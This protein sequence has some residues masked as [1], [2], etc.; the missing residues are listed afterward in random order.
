M[1]VLRCISLLSDDG[2]A[3]PIIFDTYIVSPGQ[4]INQRN[5]DVPE[6]RHQKSPQKAIS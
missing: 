5:Q 6:M 4:V 2:I 3:L 1:K